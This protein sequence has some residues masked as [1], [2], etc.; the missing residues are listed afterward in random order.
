MSAALAEPNAMSAPELATRPQLVAW[1]L[2][3]TA[4]LL[5]PLVLA[6]VLRVIGQL[7]GIAILVVAML[8]VSGALALWPTVWTMVALALSK[9]VLRYLEQFSGHFVAFAALARLRD[10]FYARLAPQAPAA[11]EGPAVGS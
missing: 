11:T 2:R 1:L 7:A 9:A 6:T 3:Q 4:P 10:L 8:G 5:W